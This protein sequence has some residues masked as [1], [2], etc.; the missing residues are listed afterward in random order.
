MKRAILALTNLSFLSFSQADA[1]ADKHAGIIDTDDQ[2]QRDDLVH[3]DQAGQLGLGK[4]FGEAM[5]KTLKK[6]NL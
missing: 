2:C 4:R 6:S 3:Y 5:I 1:K